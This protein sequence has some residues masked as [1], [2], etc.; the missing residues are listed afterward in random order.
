[1]FNK[2]NTTNRTIVFTAIILA[3]AAWVYVIYHYSALPENVVAH[4]DH[5][6]N[7]DRYD[8][9]SVLWWI[10]G[11]FS[12]VGIIFYSLSGNFKFHNLQLQDKQ[13]QR[14][15]VLLALPYIYLI[16]LIVVFVMIQKTLTPDFETNWLLYLILGLTVVFLISL[17]SYSYKN[18]KS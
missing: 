3:L 16:Q 2:L 1:M 5:A 17:F 12:A 14:S 4:M 8:H 15:M 18:L 7:V 10:L 9:K 11:I 13:K 6:G